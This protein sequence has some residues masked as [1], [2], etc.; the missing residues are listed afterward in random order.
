MLTIPAK[1]RLIILANFVM[2]AAVMVGIDLSHRSVTVPS[3]T[4]EP[5]TFL[6]EVAKRFEVAGADFVKV[7]SPHDPSAIT[8]LLDARTSL[9]FIGSIFHLT[10]QAARL[11]SITAATV[12]INDRNIPFN[13]DQS[14]GDVQ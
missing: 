9:D 13:Q 14:A 4:T 2:P 12:T 11:T 3:T 7:P 10:R 8:S 6:R 1:C 5:R